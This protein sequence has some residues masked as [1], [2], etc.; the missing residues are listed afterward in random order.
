MYAAAKRLA[1]YNSVPLKLDITSGFERDPFKRAYCLDRFHI[2]DIPISPSES[3]ATR[4]VA[5]PFRKFTRI[6]NACLPYSLRYYIREPKNRFDGRLLHLRVKRDLILEGYWQDSRYFED[7]EELLRAKLQFRVTHEPRNVELSRQIRNCNSVALHA[8]RLQPNRTVPPEYY[9]QAIE[10][11]R[12]TVPNPVLFC[13]SDHPQWFR[14]NFG[15]HGDIVIVE[16]NGES[17]N[18]EDLWLQSCCK[19]HIIANSTFSWWGAWLSASPGKIVVS[20]EM[21]HRGQT[22]RLP[23]SWQAHIIAL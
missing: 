16:G 2:D 11:M 20:P 12:R 8:R 17:L 6:V 4:M 22:M 5:G 1:L 14:D 13:F 15:R 18:H 19:H 21:A 23:K 9:R 3:A 10:H 7:M